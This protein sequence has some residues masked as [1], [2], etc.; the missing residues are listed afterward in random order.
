MLFAGERPASLGAT[1]ALAREVVCQSAV[2]AQAATTLPPSARSYRPSCVSFSQ[3]E[4]EK[5]RVNGGGICNVLA[6]KSYSPFCAYLDRVIGTLLSKLSVVGRPASLYCWCCSAVWGA[7]REV[8]PVW[9]SR[10]A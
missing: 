8:E 9:A 5:K 4:S 10:G 6:K 1:G 7:R 3:H 2:L